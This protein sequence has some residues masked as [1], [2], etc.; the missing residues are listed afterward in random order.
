MTA[1]YIETSI[2]PTAHCSNRHS[3]WLV[4]GAMI[5][6][7]LVLGLFPTS[8]DDIAYRTVE[9][10]GFNPLALMVALLCAGIVRVIGLW[11]QGYGPP[12]CYALRA[13][14]AAAAIYIW[15]QIAL[16]I[17]VASVAD[18]SVH[19]TLVL[20]AMLIVADTLGCYRAVLDGRTFP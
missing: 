8:L 2:A 18:G 3:E 1:V 20:Y 12:L 7:A 16:A 15:W 11:F 19:L 6:M 4:A 14:G 17:L 5:A 10:V 9:N 13:F